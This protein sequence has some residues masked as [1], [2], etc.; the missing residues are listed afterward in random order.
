VDYFLFLLVNATLFI[1][2]SEL[3]P[4][5]A[6]I[7]I[8][9]I[10]IVTCL[11]VSFSQVAGLLQ[12]RQLSAQPVTMCV[13][14]V[15]A[16][17]VAS[18]VPVLGIRLAWDDAIEFLKVVVYYLL[19]ISVLTT[20]RRLRG[21]LYW[22]AGFTVV[23]SALAVMQ[24]FELID[25]PTLSAISDSHYNSE[26]GQFTLIERIRATGIFQDPNDLAMIVVAS[27][28]ICLMGLFDS[29]N[30]ALRYL[31]LAPLA[32]FGLTLALTHSRGGML[33]LV[34]SLLSLIYFRYGLW[35]TVLAAAVLFPAATVLFEGRQTDFSGGM[36]SGTGAE[37]VDYW[38]EGLQMLKGAP[39]FGIG[40]GQF[41]EQVRH[42]PHNSFIQ[43][44]VELGLFGGTLFFGVYWFALSSTWRLSR[45]QRV[46]VESVNGGPSLTYFQP[47]LFAALVAFTIAQLSLSRS[48]IVATYLFPGVAT[49]SD[50]LAR[51]RGWAPAVQVSFPEIRRLA[52]AGGSFL[53]ATYAY[54]RFVH[55]G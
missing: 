46:S 23:V 26:A 10:L 6:E 13:L 53:L 22:T 49:V 34:G 12:W 35:R 24:H 37:R 40:N 44:F 29:S 50:L 52:L 7:P 19:L 3:F 18:D 8:Y 11:F 27:A 16:A 38:S 15:L 36:S 17:I 51:R 1:R 33:A 32:L 25:L 5:L 28:T 31:W 9:N 2:P 20:T 30:G 42:V 45:Q 14:G 43:S 48:M 4:S 21:F 55:H 39:I 54:I 41:A 47:F